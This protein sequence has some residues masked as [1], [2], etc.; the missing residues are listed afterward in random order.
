MV[1][2]LMLAACL[3]ASDAPASELIVPLD[4]TRVQV[5]GRIM[6]ERSTRTVQFPAQ[7]NQHHGLIEY[8]L[9]HAAGKRHE[10]LLITNV[11]PQPPS[12]YR[13]EIPPAAASFPGFPKPILWDTVSARQ[14][15]LTPAES[16]TKETT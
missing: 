5:A 4:D 10:A 1:V 15:L 13:P 11:E 2:L 14:T 3:R 12:A 6:V 8:L 7:V 9:V 16:G